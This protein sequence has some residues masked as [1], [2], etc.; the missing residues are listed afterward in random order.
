MKE[1]NKYIVEKLKV[2]KD[3]KAIKDCQ[4]AYEILIK[5]LKK[6]YLMIIFIKLL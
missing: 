1:L 3:V 5:Y 6:K 2:N 4:D